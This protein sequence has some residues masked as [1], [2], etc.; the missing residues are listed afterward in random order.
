MT[1]LVRSR[2]K[3]VPLEK[4]RPFVPCLT[5]LTKHATG[6]ARCCDK[7]RV[8]RK[9]KEATGQAN[10]WQKFNKGRVSHQKLPAPPA[11]AR[12]FFR[13]HGADHW[14]VTVIA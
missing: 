7:N 8:Y 12:P 6:P 9:D 1:S 3:I 5:R 14:E 11:L 2:L 4:C 10:S 13:Y